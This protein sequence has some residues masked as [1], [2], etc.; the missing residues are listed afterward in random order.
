MYQLPSN[1]PLLHTV[2]FTL[3]HAYYSHA[4]SF[5]IL[6]RYDTILCAIKL[7]IIIKTPL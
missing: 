5:L 7:K 3:L 4:V 2:C 6:Y 1:N